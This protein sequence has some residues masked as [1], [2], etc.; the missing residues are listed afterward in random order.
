MSLPLPPVPLLT[1]RR[2]PDRLCP[3]PQLA[4]W[5][6]NSFQVLVINLVVVAVGAG[7]GLTFISRSIVVVLLLAVLWSQCLVALA[8][9]SST[10]YNRLLTSYAGNALLTLVPAI[11]CYMLNAN[12]SS[13]AEFPTVSF[14]L[15]PVAY[16]R[17][18]HLLTQRGYVPDKLQGEMAA[19][20]GMLLLDAVLCARALR[21]TS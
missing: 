3:P 14:L 8:I 4:E 2:S 7:A 5:A 13:N 21:L 18:I 9:L 6:Y 19:I 1:Q 12:V 15:A 10:V 16:F 11:A 17:A 20:I